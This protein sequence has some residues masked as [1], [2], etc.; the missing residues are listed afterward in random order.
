MP[1]RTLVPRITPLMRHTVTH[2]PVIIHTTGAAAAAAP[3]YEHSFENDTE[4]SPWWF[5]NSAPVP[6]VHPNQTTTAVSHG[7]PSPTPILT[8]SAPNQQPTLNQD[9]A[10]KSH[11]TPPPYTWVDYRLS[12]V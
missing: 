1:S 4:F 9:P 10:K 3:H 2:P 12:M 8:P 5:A 11:Y 6:S 7:P